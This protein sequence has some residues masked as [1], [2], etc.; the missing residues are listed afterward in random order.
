VPFPLREIS[1]C[2]IVAGTAANALERSQLFENIQKVNEQLQRLAVTDGLTGLY[3]HRYFRDRLES[4]FERARRYMVPLSCLIMDIDNFKKVNDTFGHLQG[5]SILREIA[6]RTLQTVRKSDIV[7]RYGGEEFV[8]IM[9]QTGAEGAKA[10]A[11]RICREISEGTFEGM[12]T[13]GAVT[14]SV[15]VAVFDPDRMF[16]CE[17]LIRVADGALYR[18]KHEGKN[19]V[20]V[21]EP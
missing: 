12:P 11:D 15:G 13:P 14:V 20:I 19:R 9:P 5:D 8:V 1:F 16:D 2:E 18:A 6:A 3:N 17:A 4:E 10:Y 7:A 21:G